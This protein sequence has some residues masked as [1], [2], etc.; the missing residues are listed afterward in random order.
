MR[1]CAHDLT[2][3]APP[4]AVLDAFFDAEALSTWWQVSR[5]VCVPRPFGSFAL[6]WES[7]RWRDDLLGHLGGSLHGTVV[8]FVP[9]REFFVADLYW[10]PPEGNPIGPMA[11]EA[12]CRVEGSSTLLHLRQSGYDDSSE[13]WS[14]YYDIMSNGW[15]LALEGLKRYLEARWSEGGNSHAL[16]LEKI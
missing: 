4:A 6:E 15:V 13:R 14:R 8:D 10:H 1:E 12:T 16:K 9:G 3:N 11:L 5:S 7:T 2:I